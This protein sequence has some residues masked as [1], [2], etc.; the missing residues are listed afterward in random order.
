MTMKS[1]IHPSPA[2]RSVLRLS[3]ASALT[4]VATA[5][6]GQAAPT[7][8]A[9]DPA[10]A[11]IIVTALKRG[12]ALQETP[13]SISAI[14]PTQLANSGVKSIADLSG[15]VPSLTIVDAGPGFRRVVI[16]GIR[17]T[18]EPT[19]GTY[20]D[21]TAVTGLIGAGND[22]G[23]STPDLHLF[24]VERIEVLRGPQGTL[25]GSG[26]MGGTLRIIYDKPSY[27][28]EGAADVTL[29]DTHYGGFNYELNGMINLPVVTDKV[30]VRAVGYY[31]HNT[32]YID[33][34]YLH[35]NNINSAEAYGGRLMV[36]LQPTER[37]T[38]DGDAYY[39]HS[40][41]DTPGWITEVG[42][43]ETDNRVRLPTHDRTELFSGTA[44]YDLDTV[45]ATGVV[46]Y[47]DRNLSSVG[48][49]SRYIGALATA[50]NFTRFCS[51]GV[52]CVS[53]ATI[54]TPVTTAAQFVNFVNAQSVSALF[55]QQELH[56]LTAELRLSNTGSGRFHWTVGGFYSRRVTDVANP[57]LNADPISGVL[58]P[59]QVDTVRYIHDVLK[60]V[61]AFVDLSYDIT[62]KLNITAGARYFDYDKGVVGHTDVPS[63]LVGATVTPPTALSSSEHGQVV[64]VNLSYKFTRDLMFYFNAA[65]GFRPGGVN[66]VLGLASALTP[67]RSDSLWNYE[68]GLKTSWFNRRLT[69]DIDVFRIDWS[70]IQVTQRTPNGAFSYIGN[71]AAARVQGIEFEG[72][73]RPIKGLDFGYNATYMTA[74]LTEDQL[75]TALMTTSSGLKG[76][77]IPFV[78]KFQAGASAQYVWPI[79]DRFN[80]LV[81]GDLV[82]QG[83][84]YSDFRTTYIY[85][86]H[87]PGYEL[88][89]ARVGIEAPN[90]KWGAYLFVTNLFD[91]V[92]LLNSGSSAIGVGLTSV[93]TAPPR[94]IGVNL[95]TKF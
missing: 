90:G 27:R 9:I 41:T 26:S 52:T 17:A 74:V 49:T 7:T 37:L 71:A 51:N 18:G 67:Y 65:Q 60:Q 87:L 88:V 61:A 21:E 57:Q 13:I 53:P 11:D 66:Q 46:S 94:T 73:W 77:R 55:P 75:P 34:I 56:A 10:N 30:A 24:D 22:A 76:N 39:D 86:R 29:S 2:R 58:I 85:T 50:A 32:G 42:K 43:Y 80:A 78:P 59:S 82:H 81:R 48:D 40:T 36:R 15:H 45:R 70:N 44:V 8:D 93:V 64:K 69:A 28:T 14:T 63:P 12:S 3:A 6:W 19:V 68:A 35:I 38:I 23:G 89:N 16:R 54:A 91:K 72:G 83:G 4:L 33:N 84:S 25:Y 1:S 79:S 20:Y 92:A 47:M 5:A 95:R 31:R 62:S